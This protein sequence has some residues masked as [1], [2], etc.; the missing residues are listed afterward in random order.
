MKKLSVLVALILCVTIGGVYATWNYAQNSAEKVVK[1]FDDSTVITSSVT[2]TAKGVINVDTSELDIIIDDANN[3][4]QGELR[5]TGKVV[6]TFA[7]S[8]GADT[9]VVNNGI[10]LQYSLGTTTDYEYNGND[11]FLVDSTAQT[12]AKGKTFEISSDKLD[13]LI[14][15]NTLNLPTVEDYDNFKEALHRGGISI[16]VSEA[17][18]FS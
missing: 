10:A 15:L 5:I 12:L 18:A 14:A 17:P 6:I 16:T 11:I 3:D 8:N 13:D 1:Y 9:D 4:Y 2:E 7:P